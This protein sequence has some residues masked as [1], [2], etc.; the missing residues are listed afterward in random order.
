MPR[1]YFDYGTLPYTHRRDRVGVCQFWLSGSCAKSEEEC[2]FAHSGTVEKRPEKCRFYAN[3]T[4]AK[5]LACIFMH[6][7]H[8]CAEFVIDQC[9]K[10]DCKFS[11]APLTDDHSRS[12]AKEVPLSIL[13]ILNSVRWMV[14]LSAMFANLGV[15]DDSFGYEGQYLGSRKRRREGTVARW[16]APSSD[17][18]SFKGYRFGA[19]SR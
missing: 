15:A 8:P 16:F 4:C 12:L 2:A 6:E 17:N 10:S 9:D 11:H 13:V 3:S 1:H 7:T 18:L 19:R 5:G 14:L